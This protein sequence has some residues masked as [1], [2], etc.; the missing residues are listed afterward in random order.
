LVYNNLGRLFR[1]LGRTGDAETAY[2]QALALQDKLVRENPRVADYRVDLATTQ[3]NLGN[4]YCQTN[5]KDKAEDYYRKSLK[6]HES[7]VRDHPE[8]S[9]YGRELARSYNGLGSLLAEAKRFQEAEPLLRQSAEV[10]QKLAEKEPR[11]LVYAYERDRAL[12]HLCEIYNHSSRHAQAESVCRDLLPRVERL[13]RDQ[14]KFVEITILLGMAQR[15][16]GQ[17]VSGTEHDPGE[18]LPWYDRALNTLKSAARKAP[19]SIEILPT[20]RAIYTERSK[21]LLKLARHD[22]A[23]QDLD[24]AIA[25]SPQPNPF[26]TA[27]KWSAQTTAKDHALLAAKAGELAN[28]PKASAFLF[29]NAACVLARSS[30]LVRDDSN[31]PSTERANLAEQYAKQAL[32][33]LGKAQAAGYFKD[34]LLRKQ[35][36]TESDLSALRERDDFKQWLSALAKIP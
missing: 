4:L 9:Y 34:P 35:L 7:L 3:N 17:A 29:Y 5:E 12:I 16:M 6:G 36:T 28:R 24:Q 21:C 10:L 11:I 33:W 25:L 2:L 1:P 13:A 15:Q 27:A 19:Q 32:D 31:L 18:A 20:L 26:L 22:A 30:A 14:P 23:I 8:N